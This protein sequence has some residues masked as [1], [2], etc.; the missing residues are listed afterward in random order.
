[1]CSIKQVWRSASACEQAATA[2]NL[3]AR[4]QQ[5]LN[6]SF[7]SRSAL[8]TWNERKSETVKSRKVKI[9]R[10]R[11]E[12]N[13]RK[14]IKRERESKIER[15]REREINKRWKEIGKIERKIERE[16]K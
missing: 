15:K 5:L 14:N 12:K 2:A 7:N 10:E 4:F 6:N 3:K 8:P 11:N 16:K 1:M 9:E 13:E